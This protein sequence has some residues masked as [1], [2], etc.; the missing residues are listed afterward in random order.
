[1]AQNEWE[2]SAGLLGPWQAL[3]GICLHPRVAGSG[4]E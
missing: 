4:D 2:C 3:V 1:V